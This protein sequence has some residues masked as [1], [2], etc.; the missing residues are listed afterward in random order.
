MKKVVHFEVHFV[1]LYSKTELLI[2][3][4]LRFLSYY[5]LISDCRF[6]LNHCRIFLALPSITGCQSA[7]FHLLDNITTINADNNAIPSNPP[8][9]VTLNISVSLKNCTKKPCNK[10]TYNVL[11]PSGVIAISFCGIHANTDA[12]INVDVIYTAN[13]AN[14]PNSTVPRVL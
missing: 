11:A 7:I 5:A 10:Y 2:L 9:P 14:A 12:A 6:L 13:R 4:S 8:I 3:K 1:I